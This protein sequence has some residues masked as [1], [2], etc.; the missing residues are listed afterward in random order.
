MNWKTPGLFKQ[1]DSEIVGHYFHWGQDHFG[2]MVG[3]C[4]GMSR[5]E[6]VLFMENVYQIIPDKLKI[7]GPVDEQLKH[8]YMVSGAALKNIKRITRNEYMLEIL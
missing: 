1:P 5:S 4:I 3:L 7:P 6:P 8:H 2:T